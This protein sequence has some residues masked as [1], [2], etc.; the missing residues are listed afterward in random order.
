MSRFFSY[1]LFAVG[2]AHAVPAGAG[3]E[4]APQPSPK[5]KITYRLQNGIDRAKLLFR[6]SG[7]L[8][9]AGQPVIKQWLQPSV[10]DRVE[11]LFGGSNSSGRPKIEE[12]LSS[13]TDAASPAESNPLL[14]PP[15]TTRTEAN[16]DAIKAQSCKFFI[17]A[18]MAFPTE[19]T[20][21]EDWIQEV[22]L[23]PA[24]GLI[25]ELINLGTD[26]GSLAENLERNGC[27]NTLVRKA[28][29]AAMLLA[30]MAQAIRN[31]AYDFYQNADPERKDIFY[32]TI[33]EAYNAV[34]G[35]VVV[36][37][38]RSFINM[39]CKMDQM[40]QE[41]QYAWETVTEQAHFEENNQK[42]NIEGTSFADF[43]NKFTSFIYNLVYTTNIPYE[44]KIADSSEPCTQGRRV[45]GERPESP[46]ALCT[47]EICPAAFYA[48]LKSTSPCYREKFDALW[49]VVSGAPVE[50]LSA[51]L[52]TKNNHGQSLWT[53]ICALHP[54]IARLLEILAAQPATPDTHTRHG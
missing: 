26:A 40:A 28:E 36:R 45:W 44:E 39:L 23:D 27:D 32:N 11:H 42:Y 48:F 9:D 31:M 12:I 25:A 35:A 16:A 50:F 43:T 10:F 13:L 47:S 41:L 19:G 49:S 21:L 30:N 18:E 17:V 52:A 24:D 53:V 54:G 15:T 14:I 38:L 1:I 20:A 34:K 37:P 8:V 7:V 6:H 2:L 3:P 29:K 33:K 5:Q 22:F 46:R 51:A 4:A